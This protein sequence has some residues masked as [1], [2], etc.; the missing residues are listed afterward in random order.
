MTKAKWHGALG[1]AVC[2]AVCA[3][4][5]PAAAQELPDG[6]GKE[7]I[8]R[9]CTGCH[10]PDAFLSYRHTKDEYQAIVIRMGQRGARA[11]NEELDLVADYLAKNFLKVDEA[12]KVNV[13][14]ASAAEIA[15]ALGLSAKEA[16]AVV[17]YRER[18]GNYRALGDLYLIYGVDGRKF[19]SQAEKISF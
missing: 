17:S 14:K 4:A 19:Q 10:K 9:A 15:T 7:I 12:G 8:L 16:E 13:N 3:F 5:L 11:N 2:L 18:R 1:F 6:A